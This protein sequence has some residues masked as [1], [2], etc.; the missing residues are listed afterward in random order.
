MRYLLDTGILVRALHRPDP[1]NASIRQALR[2]LHSD[3]HAL[4]CAR[5]N[6][7]EFWSLCTRPAA[8][9]GGFGLTVEETGRRLRILERFVTVLNEPVSTH[10]LWK[11]LVLR[12]RVSGKQ[13]HDARIAAVM[14]AYR[15]R[16]ILTLNESDFVRY[17][18]IAA[19]SPEALIKAK[20]V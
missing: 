18:E 9:R 15:V 14:L 1:E 3:G 10:R 8:S 4:V 7:V 6:I 11:S 16:R 12:H 20:H 5:Q 13:V 17:P 19:I 2:S